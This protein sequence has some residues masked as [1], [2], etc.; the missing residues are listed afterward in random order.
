M[1]KDNTL[2]V[3]RC[4]RL[5][6]EE[7]LHP[8]ASVIKLQKPCSEKQICPN[9]YAV[10]FAEYK[11]NEFKYGRKPYDYSDATMLFSAPG[12]PIDTDICRDGALLLFHPD[13]IRCT[14]LGQK[15]NDYTYFLYK[16]NEALHLSCREKE[17]I[18]HC[19]NDIDKELNW[20]VD[21]FTK[22]LIN[23]KIETLLNYSLRFY[24]RQ[25]ITRHDANSKSIKKITNLLDEYLL[26][27]KASSG[28]M[29]TAHCFA[30]KMSMSAAY[31]DDM[32]QHE[33]GK[34]TVDYVN[35]RRIILAKAQLMDTRKSVTE[36]ADTLG[37]CNATC[38]SSLF[39]KI[40]GCEPECYRM[41]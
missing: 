13:L 29:P 2:S 19:I 34:D 23:N 37:F 17:C 5:F 33:T 3:C 9:C 8:L 25:F 21:R 18:Q 30:P 22:T 10:T 38:F 41:Q 36:I 7:T 15:I 39:K 24:N 16:A 6:E 28:I 20:G 40:T 4:N 26:S 32:L 1:G 11:A 27:G 12:K 35:M 14:C 31:L